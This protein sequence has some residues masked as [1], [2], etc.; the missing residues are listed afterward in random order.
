MR[1]NA[2]EMDQKPSLDAVDPTG[3]R[4]PARQGSAGQSRL[5]GAAPPPDQ[6]AAEELTHGEWADRIRV[7]LAQR[8]AHALQVA[9]DA[10]RAWPADA[11]ILLLAAL[12]ALASNLPD[13][14]L[15]LLKRYGKR[16]V[17]GKVVALLTAL[18]LAQQGHFPQAWAKLADEQLTTDREAHNWFIGNTVMSHWL[19]DR[20]REIRRERLR[21]TGPAKA[22]AGATARSTAKVR[23]AA[24]EAKKDA[25]P[26]T[27]AGAAAPVAPTLPALVELPRLEAQFDMTFGLA[28]PEA[29]EIANGAETHD[30]DLF[31]LRGELVRL[32]SLRG[33]RRIALPAGTA[34]C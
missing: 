27:P 12:T 33:I 4:E 10:L 19:F 14:A 9:E 1:D 16:Y 8:S 22:T 17:S 34:R 3:S 29:I 32:S 15:R 5:S 28:N 20:L 6:P 24:R 23:P 7:A 2:L 18:A 13:R 31:D 30:A 26:K 11:E 25:S 21:A